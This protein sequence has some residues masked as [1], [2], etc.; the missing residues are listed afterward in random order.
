MKK[1]YMIYTTYMV[2]GTQK[3]VAVLRGPSRTRDL[4]AHIHR[5]DAV[6]TQK[7]GLS[8]FTARV[9]L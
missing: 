9:S 6:G 7:A 1:L 2:K 5:H 8:Q 3:D 4:E